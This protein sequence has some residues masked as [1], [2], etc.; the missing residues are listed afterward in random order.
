[1]KVYNYG[2]AYAQAKKFENGNA[3]NQVTGSEQSAQSEVQPE[4]SAAQEETKAKKSSKKDKSD[5]SD[6]V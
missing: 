4:A 6:N 3:G 5:S 1:M 2:N